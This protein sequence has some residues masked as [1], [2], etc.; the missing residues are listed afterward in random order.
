MVS[1]IPG[2]G[3][4]GKVSAAS[5]EYSGEKYD[6][7]KSACVAGGGLYKGIGA[8]LGMDIIE[9]E[10]ATALPNTNLVQLESNSNY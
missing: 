7:Q 4:V 6:F 2:Y 8:Y 5:P 1:S 10:G 9:V 3:K